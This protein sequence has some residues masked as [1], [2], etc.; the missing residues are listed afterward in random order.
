MRHAWCVYPAG[1][2]GGV[3]GNARGAD[4]APLALS[5]H[6]ISSSSRRG[7]SGPAG[8]HIL[9]HQNSCRSRSGMQ[10]PGRRQPPTKRSRTTARISHLSFATVYTPYVLA[11][12]SKKNSF[13]QWS[14]KFNINF[15]YFYKN[16]YHKVIYLYFYG[17]IFQYKSIHIFFVF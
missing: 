1:P 4:R 10:G 16:I 17:T 13:R 8:P 7:I 5:I 12:Y 3:C 6:D 2:A 14:P 11:P 15:L 9:L